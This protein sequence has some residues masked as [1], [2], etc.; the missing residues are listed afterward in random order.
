MR[1]NRGAKNKPE[2]V[3]CGP[4]GLGA[5]RG[6]TRKRARKENSRQRK[7][8]V[9]ERDWRYIKEPR[10]Q[11]AC[12]LEQIGEGQGETVGRGQLL[13]GVLC[14]WEVLGVLF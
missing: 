6:R 14:L 7:L 12:A 11:G 1:H 13:D 9:K 8:Y 5:L 2:G 3:C 4:G 10:N